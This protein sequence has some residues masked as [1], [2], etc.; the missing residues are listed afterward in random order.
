MATAPS[1]A[2]ERACLRRP[3]GR[4]GHHFFPLG[5]GTASFAGVN[6]IGAET[7]TRL[8]S[9]AIEALMMLAIEAMA[10]T[11]RVMVD[12]SAQYG[13]SESRIGEFLATRPGASEQLYL[14]TK[15]GL[16]FHSEELARQDY[17]MEN[18]LASVEASARRL[19]RIELLYLHTNPG[20]TPRT[21]EEIL[22]GR[23]GV[24][25]R[26]REMKRTR[27][28]GIAHLGISASTPEALE[29]LLSHRDLVADFDA[30]QLNAVLLLDRVDLAREL[31]RTHFGV[32]LNSPYRKADRHLRATPEGLRSLYHRVLE[33]HPDAVI[34]T[35]TRSPAH[36]RQNIEHVRTWARLPRLEIR[37]SSSRPDDRVRRRPTSRR[38][39]SPTSLTSRCGRRPGPW[40]APRPPRSA[41]PLPRPTTS[42]RPSPA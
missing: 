26:M 30:L 28:F 42:P 35:G 20:V 38:I 34:L 33:T 16:R 41:R 7:Y 18:L 6:M 12:T 5:L 11:R 8:S 14:A 22:R 36:L 10:E 21:L 29:L 9:Q 15:W 4:T 17:S 31:R 24:V 25:D 37:Y 19:G 23:G 2:D 1:V 40:P 27:R 39:S 13:E 32:V 3:F